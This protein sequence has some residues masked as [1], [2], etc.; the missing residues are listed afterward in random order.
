MVP[1]LVDGDH[2]IIEST[3]IMEY[4]DTAYSPDSLKPKGAYAQAQMR[5]WTKWVDETL[6]PN[7]PGIAWNTLIRPTWLIQEPAGD[8]RA[9]RQAD[10][11]GAARAAIAIAQAG[12]QLAG[13]LSIR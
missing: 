2:T 13:V 6:H 9:A 10:R 3:I 4:L 7:W 5:K 11:S 8:R 1:A 12:L